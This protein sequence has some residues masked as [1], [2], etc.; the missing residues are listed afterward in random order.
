MQVN[1]LAINRNQDLG[2]ASE[3]SL[4]ESV[5]VKLNTWLNR[6]VGCWHKELSRP[7]SSQGQTYRV[8]I[9]CGA[10]RTFNVGRWEMQ[11][12]F[13]FSLPTSKHFGALSGLTQRRQT[14]QLAPLH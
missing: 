5:A 9:H 3:F 1:Q 7:F 2:R 12:G 11:G 10:R 4:L 14:N 6:M 13:Y 8:C